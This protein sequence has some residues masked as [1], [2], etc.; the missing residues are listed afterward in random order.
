MSETY[1]PNDRQRVEV[2]ILLP[3]SDSAKMT[4]LMEETLERIAAHESALFDGREWY[5]AA[6]VYDDQ[7][8]W[9]MPPQPRLRVVKGH[10]P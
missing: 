8:V 2:R 7:G 6:D 3:E 1:W 10:N 9:S 4:A 5:A